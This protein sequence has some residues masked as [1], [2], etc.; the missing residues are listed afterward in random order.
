[1]PPVLRSRNVVI[2]VSCVL[3]LKSYRQK[4]T[5]SEES[6]PHCD[7]CFKNQ[8]IHSN[9]NEVFAFLRKFS[10][11]CISILSKKEITIWN[12][13]Q[14]MVKITTGC[15]SALMSRRIPHKKYKIPLRKMSSL[16]LNTWHDKCFMLTSWH[17]EIGRTLAKFNQLKRNK[18][19][20]I[21]HRLR[22]IFN[23]GG[24]NNCERSEHTQRLREAFTVQGYFAS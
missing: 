4:N 18:R 2:L 17:G 12:R 11:G 8:L 23:M 3:S 15:C 16:H 5:L 6:R 9:L 1:M 20:L 7:Q 13:E 10:F 19:F 14:N 21:M 24:S 22:K